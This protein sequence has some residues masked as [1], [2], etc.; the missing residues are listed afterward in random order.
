MGG[1]L[2]EA[3]VDLI[4]GLT[5]PWDDQAFLCV[6]ETMCMCSSQSHSCQEPVL[7]QSHMLYLKA[8]ADIV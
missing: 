8:N 5:K 2:E 3:A 4:R 1:Q 7:Q 6:C